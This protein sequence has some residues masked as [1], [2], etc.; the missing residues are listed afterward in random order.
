MQLFIMRHGQA[1]PSGHIDSQRQL[2][3]SGK[4]EAKLMSQWLNEQAHFFDEIF[5]SPFIRAQQT[6]KIVVEGMCFPHQEKIIDFITPSGSA[7][8]VHDY[9]DGVCTEGKAKKI[10][11]VSH[12][13]LVSYLVAE[14]TYDHQS[15]I[16]Q[17]A[18]IAHIDYNEITMK[19]ELL[20]LV[21]PSDVNA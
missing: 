16:F 18:S 7:K 8:Q 10:L 3:L 13:P 12:M 20:T 6:A 21:S 17:T 15:P 11:L 2:M 9:I 5:V 14:L 1:D 19:G 4:V